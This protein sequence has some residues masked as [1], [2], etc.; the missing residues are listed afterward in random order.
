[1]SEGTRPFLAKSMGGCEMSRA[2]VRAEKDLF[3]NWANSWRPKLGR[4]LHCTEL[5]FQHKQKL[6][7]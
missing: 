2:D 4:A 7:A 5:D 1:M 6:D 3:T